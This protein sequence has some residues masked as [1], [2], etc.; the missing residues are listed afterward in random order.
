MFFGELQFPSAKFTDAIKTVL[1]NVLFRE[2]A[3]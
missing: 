2:I 3:V 1:D